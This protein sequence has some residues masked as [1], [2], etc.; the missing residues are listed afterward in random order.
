[1]IKEDIS[2][3]E[4]GIGV[5]FVVVY[6]HCLAVIICKVSVPGLKLEI[7]SVLSRDVRINTGTRI[8]C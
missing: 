2:I 1:M 5:V 7:G 3:A 6:V 8:K 4:M